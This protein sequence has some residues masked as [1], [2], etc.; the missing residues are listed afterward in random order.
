[1]DINRKSATKTLHKP[2][3]GFEY[4]YIIYDD[5]SIYDMLHKKLLKVYNGKVTV[6]GINNKEYAIPVNKLYKLSF[7]NSMTDLVPV[8]G[9]KGYYINKLGA[10]YNSNSKR[11]IRTTIKNGYLRYNVNWKRRLVHQVLAD[12]FIPNPNNYNSIDHKD[13]NKLNN[14]LTNLEWCD[15]EE[16]KKRA[17]DNGL[18]RIIKTS[19]TFIKGDEHFTLL[20]LE[21]ASK[22]FGITKST[23]STMIKRYGNKDIVIPSGSMKGYKIITNKCKCEVQ[24]LEHCS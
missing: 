19:V 15:I 18:T 5:C 9:H 24:R 4:R 21:N 17:Y 10:L 16:N 22:I 13:C 2:L 20:G 23:L 11:Y 1:M 14:A 8:I 6:I 12:Q 3:K 7:N